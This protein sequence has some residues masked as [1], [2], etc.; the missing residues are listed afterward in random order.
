MCGSNKLQ[1]TTHSVLQSSS[2]HSLLT[3]LYTNVEFMAN[4]RVSVSKETKVV[5]QWLLYLKIM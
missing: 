4:P 3:K 1:D 2:S 5:S